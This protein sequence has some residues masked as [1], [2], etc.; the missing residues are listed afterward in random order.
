MKAVSYLERIA[1]VLIVPLLC[2]A[3][4][5]SGK[6]C[7]ESPKIIQWLPD[8]KSIEGWQLDDKPDIYTPDS[9]Y[10][11]VNGAAPLYH[12]YGFKKL[13]R[14]HYKNEQ[15]S[16]AGITVDIYDQGDVSGGFGVYSSSRHPDEHFL[17]IGTEAYIS[18]SILSAWK[19]PYY[20][21]LSGYDEDKSTV[22]A[23]KTIAR[24]IVSKIPGD[25]VY[26]QPLKLLPQKGKVDHSE[27]YRKTDFLGFDFLSNSISALYC[28]DS[29][30]ATFFVSSCKDRKQSKEVFF[31]LTKALSERSQI[32]KEKENLEKTVFSAR[33]RS[34]GKVLT[35]TKG[36]YLFGVYSKEEDISWKQLKRL[37]KRCNHHLTKSN[38]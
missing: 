14:G 19:G 1:I 32:V 21:F 36:K 10:E 18:G 15:D 22:K 37:F 38:K 12:S 23:M 29:A 2:F 31:K 13:V 28:V 17:S 27:L 7:Q 30:T 3:S 8:S 5:D 24:R 25:D 34:L 26:P 16:T 9:L 11:A 33:N 4:Q 35:S 6:E 20:I